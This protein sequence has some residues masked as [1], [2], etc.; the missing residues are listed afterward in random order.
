MAHVALKWPGY[1]YFG[2]GKGEAGHYLWHKDG[3]K[4]H[5]HPWEKLERFDGQLQLQ[6]ETTLYVA[7]ITRLTG[8]GLTAVSWWDRSQD[9]RP[10][11]NSIFFAGPQI[12]ERAIPEY[13]AHCFPWV[14]ER[15]PQA[16][17]ILPEHRPSQASDT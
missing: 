15:L 11:S 1:L 12:H 17:E 4:F 5:A 8:W 2:C 6:P 14:V 7:N 3:Y 9:K 10:A 16:L 13:L